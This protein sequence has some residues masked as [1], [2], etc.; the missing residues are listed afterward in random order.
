MKR[1]IRSHSDAFKPI[2]TTDSEKIFSLILSE[3]AARSPEGDPGYVKMFECIKEVWQDLCDD[4]SAEE[5]NLDPANTGKKGSPIANFIM[6]VHYLFA[7]TE[8]LFLWAQLIITLPPDNLT[9][10]YF[11]FQP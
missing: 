7:N 1:P 2:G 3:L 9:P 5:C 4:G 6:Y 10:S 11:Q 8:P